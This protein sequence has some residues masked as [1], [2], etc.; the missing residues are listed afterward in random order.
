[1]VIARVRYTSSLAADIILAEIDRFRKSL[2]I[3]FE[4]GDCSST[5]VLPPAAIKAE[6]FR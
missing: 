2:L 4:F 5:P 3:G 1:L 6:S